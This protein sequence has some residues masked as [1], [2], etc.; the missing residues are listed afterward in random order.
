[1]TGKEVVY[2]CGEHTETFPLAEPRDG[3]TL[4]VS[5]RPGAFDLFQRYHGVHVFLATVKEPLFRDSHQ[6][7]DFMRGSV[8]FL[9]EAP[10]NVFGVQAYLDSGVSIAD[11][12]PIRYE[13]GEIMQENG[14]IFLSV[15]IRMMAEMYQGILS[16][17]PGTA[18]LSLTGALFYDAGDGVWANDV[19]ASLLYHR[20]EKQ[21]YIWVCMFSCGHYL[22]HAIAEGDVRF[23]VNVIDITLME[24]MPEVPDD[25]LFLGKRGDEDPDFFYDKESS[26]WL[27]AICRLDPE[28]RKYRYVFFESDSPFEGYKCIGKGRDGAETGGSF[29]K[30]NGEQY[31]L[32]GNDF[33]ATSDYRIYGKHGMSA[34]NFDY[35]DGGFRGWGTLIPIKLGSR[36]R[37]F[38]LTF[39]RHR[40]SDY[41][42]SYGN[43]YCFE[44]R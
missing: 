30:V 16:W 9:A 19:A 41:N 2:T 22:G 12:R 43:L 42:W 3:G 27:M 14:R 26:R 28:S 11:M 36:T 21:W 31:F 10:T 5:C 24:K 23:G 20:G 7:E 17:L 6:Y 39:D 4:L 8:A 35:P 34:P 25:T 29:V 18:E 37:Y 1:M 33:H 15:T 40:G 38:W 44:A 13:N 32:C